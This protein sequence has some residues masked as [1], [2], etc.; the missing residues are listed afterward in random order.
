ML[1]HLS[2]SALQ[3]NIE[4]AVKLLS[5][6]FH[7]QGTWPKPSVLGSRRLST[8]RFLW[9]S[10]KNPPPLATSPN[11]PVRRQARGKT[12]AFLLLPE[13]SCFTLAPAES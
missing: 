5:S 3:M 4:K 11:H 8:R 7:F 9:V 13:E 6:Y 10:V 1:T 2:R 12:P